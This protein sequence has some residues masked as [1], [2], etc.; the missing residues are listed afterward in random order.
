VLK[1]A[2]VLGGRVAPAV[3]AQASGVTGDALAAALDEL[4]WQR[5]LAADARGY[6][7][8]ARIVRD[9]VARDMVLAGERARILELAGR[10]PQ[11]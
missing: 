9:V 2:A 3:L 4:E 10:S 6:S 7:F 5:W 8:V 1:A 11:G